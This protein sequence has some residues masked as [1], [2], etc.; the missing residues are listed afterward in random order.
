MSSKIDKKKKHLKSFPEALGNKHSKVV[1]MN[2]EFGMWMGLREA[3]KHVYL[4]ACY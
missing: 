3:T 4:D 2:V 1:V